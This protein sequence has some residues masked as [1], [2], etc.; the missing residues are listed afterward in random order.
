MS[1]CKVISA[2]IGGI[3]NCPLIAYTSSGCSPDHPL[4]GRHERYDISSAE[5][6]KPNI[7]R[8]SFILSFDA[9]FGITG[10]PR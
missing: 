1:E 10:I 7:S 4:S 2:H 6:L 3:K 8:F 5:I 9:A